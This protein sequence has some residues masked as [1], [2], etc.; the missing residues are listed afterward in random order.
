MTVIIRQ[1]VGVKEATGK[2][3]KCELCRG[4][5]LQNLHHIVIVGHQWMKDVVIV[6]VTYVPQLD[7]M[8]RKTWSCHSQVTCQLTQLSNLTISYKQLNAFGFDY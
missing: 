8:F 5:V 6:G 7:C 4:G 2:K 3:V 1:H